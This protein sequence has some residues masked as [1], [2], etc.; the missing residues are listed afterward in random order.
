MS[1]SAESHRQWL[2]YRKKGGSPTALIAVIPSS[3]P[4][5]SE[6]TT[7]SVFRQF[8]QRKQFRAHLKDNEMVRR[9]QVVE[10]DEPILLCTDAGAW[11]FEEAIRA[12]VSTDLHRHTSIAAYCI[13]LFA[14]VKFVKGME[15]V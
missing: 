2:Q 15:G 11:Y 6:G 10:M 9:G 12:I 3:A 13:T 5:G 14:K 4:G 1:T 8:G 7:E